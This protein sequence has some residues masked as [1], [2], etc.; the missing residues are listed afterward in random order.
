MDYQ[1]YFENTKG[2]GGL[3]RF[4]FKVE[5]THHPVVSHRR[6]CGEEKVAL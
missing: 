6:C 4:I 1:A 3:G 2:I 5:V